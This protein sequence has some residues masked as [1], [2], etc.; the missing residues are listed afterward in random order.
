MAD[1]T[2]T[3]APIARLRTGVRQERAVGTG[4]S[5]SGIIDGLRGERTVTGIPVLKNT[6]FLEEEIV[7]NVH[8]NNWNLLND[9]HF[10]GYAKVTNELSEFCA[11]FEEEFNILIEPTYTG[12]LFYGVV[13]Q[14][15]KGRIESGSTILVIHSGGLQA[16]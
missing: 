6:G 16:R 11:G 3:L 10:G 7:K 8:Y 14:I 2:V 12:K 15:K 9:Y 13:D 5:I 1:R 4:G